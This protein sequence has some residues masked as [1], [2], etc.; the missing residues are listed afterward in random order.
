MWRIQNLEQK[1]DKVRSV[2]AQISFLVFL[3]WCIYI[4]TINTSEQP[5]LK[6]KRC[7]GPISKRIYGNY[8]KKTK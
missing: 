5:L 6:N 3:P 4:N 1:I 8:N 2:N 7:R